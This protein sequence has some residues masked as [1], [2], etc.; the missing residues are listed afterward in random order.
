MVIFLRV[1]ESR[2][3]LKSNVTTS[4]RFYAREFTCDKRQNEIRAGTAT[5]ST[6]TDTVARR[7]FPEG[8]RGPTKK[9]NSFENR[10]TNRL[11]DNNDRP[12]IDFRESTRLRFTARV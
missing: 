12:C 8:A 3:F 10:N 9:K 4:S 6:K 1:F 11:P 2:V 5:R 7:R